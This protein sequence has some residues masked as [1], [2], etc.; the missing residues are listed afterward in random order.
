MA[1]NPF[2]VKTDDQTVV[3]ATEIND[4]A[5]LIPN[6]I[7]GV[8][9]G[10]YSPSS[11]VTITNLEMGGT[12]RL[13][14]ASRS[15]GPRAL[16]GQVVSDMASANRFTPNTANSWTAA[17]ASA[18]CFVVV[19]L[20][21]PDGAT[22]TAYSVYIDPAGGHGALP[23]AMPQILLSSTAVATNSNSVHKTTIDSS[24]N[25][26]AYEPFHA[27]SDTISLVVDRAARRYFIVLQSEGGANAL[28]GLVYIGG[29]VT[30]TVTN[31]DDGAS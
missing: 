12:N 24:A 18:S 3:A 28:A 14:V 27:I 16:N 2:A 22:I 11:K 31:Y 9:G 15:I 20:D 21:V 4:A 6:L 25:V 10:T 13:K 26:A 7:D 30:F 5:S 17:T 23:A 29:T 8:A 1:T 19:P